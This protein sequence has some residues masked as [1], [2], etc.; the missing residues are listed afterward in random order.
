MRK[1]LKKHDVEDIVYLKEMGASVSFIGKFAHAYYGVSRPA[2]YRYVADNKEW[3][4]QAN[5]S[6][7]I[8]QIQDMMCHGYTTQ[9]I[10]DEMGEELSVINRIVC[11]N[12]ISIWKCRTL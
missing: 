4:N 2:V 10:A 7:K 5:R 6:N 1:R 12:K 3:Y 11:D 9:L 8:E